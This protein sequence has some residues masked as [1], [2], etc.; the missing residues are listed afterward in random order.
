MSWDER[1]RAYFRQFRVKRTGEALRCKQN[2]LLRNLRKLHSIQGIPS[3]TSSS[4]LPPPQVR[5]EEA[6]RSC[7]PSLP[8]FTPRGSRTT[9]CHLI[10][11]LEQLAVSERRCLTNDSDGANETLPG[12]TIR[13]PHTLRSNLT[14]NASYHW[15]FVHRTAAATRASRNAAIL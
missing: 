10:R 9:N 2:Y 12:Y 7:L 11:A 13:L 14:R 3:E 15:K 8:I 1:A 6:R 4:E 5:R